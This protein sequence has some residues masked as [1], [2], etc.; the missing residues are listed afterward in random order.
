MFLGLLNA[1]TISLDIYCVMVLDLLNARTISLDTYCVMVLRLLKISVS[2]I[3]S[4]EDH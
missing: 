4:L 2:A 1:R 3:T